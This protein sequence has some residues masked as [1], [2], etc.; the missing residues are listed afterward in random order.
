MKKLLLIALL[1]LTTIYLFLASNSDSTRENTADITDSEQIGMVSDD[2]QILES[3]LGTVP[4]AERRAKL[5]AFILDHI[6][7]DPLVL[8]QMI[9]ELDQSMDR[10]LCYEIAMG[11]WLDVNESQALAWIE[12]MELPSD[13]Q[14]AVLNIISL[15]DPDLSTYLRVVAR[16]DKEVLYTDQFW[17]IFSSWVVQS[18]DEV[19]HWLI[20]EEIDN[21]LIEVGFTALTEHSLTVAIE[22]L[23]SLEQAN[24]QQIQIAIQAIIDHF[25]VGMTEYEALLAIQSLTPYSLREELIGALLPILLNEQHLAL[26]DVD[27]VVNSL[28]PG[29][30]RDG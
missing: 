10:L 29:E 30:L 16:L 18:P 24:S 5:E 23:S 28:L 6:K 1:G 19:L 9:G 4:S 15:P 2:K 8:M 26:E 17:D 20:E 27:A 14:A 22:S 13:L 25:P 7:R 12:S 21:H 11:I 3:L